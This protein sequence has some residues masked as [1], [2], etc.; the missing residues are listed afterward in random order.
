MPPWDGTGFRYV[1]FN[2][3]M[4]YTKRGRGYIGWCCYDA[5]G[6]CEWETY[7]HNIYALRRLMREHIMV[8]HMG[9]GLLS[10]EPTP[11]PDEPL[12]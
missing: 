8:D 10:V 3:G 9:Q 5:H 12:F 6:M 1:D 2:E 7:G 4:T 11:T